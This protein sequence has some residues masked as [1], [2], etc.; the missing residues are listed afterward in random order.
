[1]KK[2]HGTSVVTGR[3]PVRGDRHFLRVFTINSCPKR[4]FLIAKEHDNPDAQKQEKKNSTK[5]K[6]NVNSLKEKCY[7]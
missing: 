5:Y 1:M 3:F 2:H 4:R 7:P 6:G